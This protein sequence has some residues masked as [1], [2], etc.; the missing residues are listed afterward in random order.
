MPTGK[1]YQY[2]DFI[3]SEGTYDSHTKRSFLF[4]DGSSITVTLDHFRNNGINNPVFAKVGNV[5]EYEADKKNSVKSFS[6]LTKQEEIES[7]KNN[8]A[9]LSA[10]A[11]KFMAQKNQYS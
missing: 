6:N 5:I 11:G 7:L 2:E 8:N 3:G 9:N 4:E 1:I 10:A